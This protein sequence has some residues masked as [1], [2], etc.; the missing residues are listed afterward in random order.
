[1]IAQIWRPTHPVNFQRNPMPFV[2]RSR[3]PTIYYAIDDYTDP[4]KQ[5]PVLLLQHGF[6]RSHKVWYSWIPYLTR[7][8]KVVRADLRG[9]GRSSHD[10]DLTREISLGAYLEDFLALI[11]AV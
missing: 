4:W 5:A 1:M 11:D 8:Y 3:K 7:Y 9:L 10:F 2:T 6:A